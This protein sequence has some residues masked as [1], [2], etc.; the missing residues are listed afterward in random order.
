MPQLLDL[1]ESEK[2]CIVGRIDGAGHAINRMRHWHTSAKYRIVFNIIN[3]E[4]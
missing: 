4:S 1:F 2:Q 3:A